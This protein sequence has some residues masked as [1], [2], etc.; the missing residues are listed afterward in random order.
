MAVKTSVVYNPSYFEPS[1]TVQAKTDLQ[2]LTDRCPYIKEYE[3]LYQD[4]VNACKDALNKY[5]AATGNFNPS[6]YKDLAPYGYDIEYYM[7]KNDALSNSIQEWLRSNNESIANGNRYLEIQRVSS[8]YTKLPSIGSYKDTDSKYRYDVQV[9]LVLRFGDAPP[10]NPHEPEDPKE[11]DDSNDPANPPTKPDNPAKTGDSDKP[12]DSDNLG[13][14]G[15]PGKVDD[16]NNPDNPDDHDKTDDSDDPETPDKLDTSGKTNPNNPPISHPSPDDIDYYT[17]ADNHHDDHRITFKSNDTTDT[18]TT[19]IEPY[20]SI[21]KPTYS[22]ENKN[23]TVDKLEHLIDEYPVDLKIEELEFHS[24][25]VKIH[26]L[27]CHQDC[28]PV[29]L[30]LMQSADAAEKRL[31]KLENIL[32]T[33]LRTLHRIAARIHINCVYYGGQS[34]Y[35]KYRA[36]R[37]LDD[38]RVDDAKLVTIDQCVFCPR[39]EPVYGQDY[40]AKI[41]VEANPVVIL[42]DGQTGYST[43]EDYATLRGQDTYIDVLPRRTVISD[44]PKNSSDSTSTDETAHNYNDFFDGMPYTQHTF[45]PTFIDNYISTYKPS[46]NTKVFPSTF[47]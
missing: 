38:N 37:C 22:D 1:E 7:R 25:Q 19:T 10:K 13:D 4:E 34:S 8:V 11:I 40:E 21:E 45:T 47:D 44:Y 31:V 14:S 17:D 20:T 23:P 12:D 39:Y 30:A 3:Q 27:R 18:K 5:R 35:H 28:K 42:D 15:K 46:P 33:V 41:D 9:M 29:A 2:A 26:D 32:S 24:P 6:A 16:P 43:I 36:I